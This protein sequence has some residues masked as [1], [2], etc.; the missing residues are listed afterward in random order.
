[1]DSTEI[2]RLFLKVFLGCLGLT[3]L[4]AMLSVL[5]GDFGEFQMKILATTATISAASICSM[6]CAAFIERKQQPNLGFAGIV[7]SACSA[8]FLIV[9]M[10]FEIESEAYWKIAA[11]AGVLAVAFA[12]AFLLL[13]PELDDA[14]RRVQS[15]SIVS[16]GVLAL[17][18]VVAVWGEIDFEWYYRI[19]AVVAIVV[20]LETLAVPILLKLRTRPGA[21]SETLVLERVRG[22]IYRDAAGRTYQLREIDTEADAS[23]D[24]DSESAPSPPVS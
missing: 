2:K 14:Q 12:H 11:T 7:L 8:V 10:W 19:L 3:A 15:A 16:I 4:I 24:E 1:M 18:I 9:G 13:L 21:E 17:L 5:G 23:Q 20:G 22:D 6:S